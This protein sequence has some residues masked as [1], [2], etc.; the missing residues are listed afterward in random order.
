M[1]RGAIGQDADDDSWGEWPGRGD[2]CREDADDDSWGE[3]QG[4]GDRCGVAEDHSD[5]RDRGGRWIDCHDEWCLD[6]LSANMQATHQAFHKTVDPNSKS[7]NKLRYAQLH[8]NAQAPGDHKL[9]TPESPTYTQVE[10]HVEAHKDDN[11]EHTGVDEP[12]RPWSQVWASDDEPDIRINNIRIP[13][14]QTSMARSR[15]RR[16]IVPPVF[17]ASEGNQRKINP[18][19][20]VNPYGELINPEDFQRSHLLEWML[21]QK[22]AKKPIREAAK[23]DPEADPEAAKPDPEADPE[24]VKQVIRKRLLQVIRK[25]IRKPITPPPPPAVKQ[26]IR[27]PITP[28]PPPGSGSAVVPPMPGSGQHRE[29]G[30][31]KPRA[32]GGTTQ[33]W[34]TAMSRA[35]TWS[36]YAESAF[37]AKFKDKTTFTKRDLHNLTDAYLQELQELGEAAAT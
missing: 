14:N 10:E 30:M 19:M 18:E 15:S 27:K 31:R 34:H 25:P 35:R 4:R 5:D 17:A 22:P 6:G 2:R 3:W 11:V 24:A 21:S 33:W 9:Q 36:P 20:D 32:R 1:T 7:E 12:H 29:N 13:L 23:P 26:V 37:I 16:K 28:P 8:K